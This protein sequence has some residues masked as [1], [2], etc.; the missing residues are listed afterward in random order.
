MFQF[1]FRTHHSTETALLKVVYDVRVNLDNNKPSVLVLLDLSAATDAV[2]H[3]IL[4][5]RLNG[6]VGLTGNVFKWFSLYLCDRQ[7]FVSIDNHS[8]THYEV[9]SGVP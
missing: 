6:H 9:T 7:F 8:A 3:Q 2:D 5:N 4:L 1:G